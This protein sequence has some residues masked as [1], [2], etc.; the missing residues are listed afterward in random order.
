MEAIQSLSN[1]LLKEKYH[2]IIAAQQR[3]IIRKI[4]IIIYNYF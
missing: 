1:E 3:Y 4:I 2:D